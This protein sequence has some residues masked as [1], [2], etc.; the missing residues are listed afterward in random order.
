MVDHSSVV[1]V[2]SETIEF[3]CIVATGAEVLDVSRVVLTGTTA[4]SSAE[5]RKSETIILPSVLRER[6]EL[7]LANWE[8]K[9]KKLGRNFGAFRTSKLQKPTRSGC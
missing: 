1:V 7:T 9:P 5:K 8:H 2:G 4:R 3:S 6:F